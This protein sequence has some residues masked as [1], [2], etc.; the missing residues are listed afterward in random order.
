MALNS[1]LKEFI[2]SLNANSVDFLIAGG[3]ALSFY[4]RLRDIAH[5]E[6]LKALEES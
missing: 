1:D 5:V 2:E 6:A 3:H 4:G